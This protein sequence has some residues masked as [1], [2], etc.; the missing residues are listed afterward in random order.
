M[1]SGMVSGDFWLEKGFPQIVQNYL[2]QYQ[3]VITTT[4]LTP[5]TEETISACAHRFDGYAYAKAHLPHQGTWGSEFHI[6]LGKA[7]TTG[8]F[9]VNPLENFAA[10]YY[11]HRGFHGHN[12]LP[13]QFSPTWYDMVLYYLHLYR[14]PTPEVHRHVSAGDWDR[15]PKGAAERAAAELRTLLRRPR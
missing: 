5:E 8:K 9:S 2:N 3:N 14:L 13:T 15:R 12:V 7:Q 10:N 1:S 11:L 4:G 6:L